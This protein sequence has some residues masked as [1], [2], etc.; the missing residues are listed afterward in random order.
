MRVFLMAFLLVS[1]SVAGVGQVV[2]AHAG[3]ACDP[4]Q[5]TC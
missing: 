3:L 2:P 5:Q 4:K 1:L